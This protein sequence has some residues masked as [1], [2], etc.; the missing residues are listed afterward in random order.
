[1]SHMCE[2]KIGK[3]RVAVRSDEILAVLENTS[4]STC[5]LYT[6][7]FPDGI[8][9]DHNYD[10]VLWALQPDEEKVNESVQDSK[11]LPQS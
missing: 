1:M 5:D 7:S 10:A 8:T 2:F 9:V 4:D 11:G 3:L 6:L